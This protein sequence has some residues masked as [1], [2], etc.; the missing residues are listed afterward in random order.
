MLASPGFLHGEG[1]GG[2][3]HVP[4]LP[5][6]PLSVCGAQLLPTHLVL[7]DPQVKCKDCGAF[8]HR[9]RSARCPLRGGQGAVLIRPGKE[10]VNPRGL[11][12]RPHLA[13]APREVEF[14]ETRAPR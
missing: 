2:R 4:W 10:N 9:T 14:P 8:G 7:S 1:E 13:S 11:P 3:A 5:L 12:Q 6:S